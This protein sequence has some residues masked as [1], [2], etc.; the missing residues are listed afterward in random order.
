MGTIER[1][2]IVKE[3]DSVVGASKFSG[4][5]SDNSMNLPV[6]MCDTSLA[7]TGGRPVPKI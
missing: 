6:N 2:S 7:G 4:M 1:P 3:V 5:S